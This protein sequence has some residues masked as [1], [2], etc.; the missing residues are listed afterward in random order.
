VVTVASI[1]HHGGTADVLEGNAGKGYHP[2]HSYSNSK[3]ANLLFAQELQRMAADRGLPLASLAAHPGVSSTGLVGDPQGMGASLLMRTVAPV[4]VKL[5][6]Q[7][8]SAGARPTLYAATQAEAGSYIGPQRFGETRGHIGPARRST[9]A[10]D[11]KLARRLWHVSE[12][13]TGFR[14]PWPS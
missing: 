12:E 4:L 2:Q 8:A 13:L 6:T 5:F 7:S 3:L 11:E 10:R 1:A 9:Y 14:Y